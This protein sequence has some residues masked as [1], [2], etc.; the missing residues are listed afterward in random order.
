[1]MSL[2]PRGIQPRG[3]PHAGVNSLSPLEDKGIG[4]GAQTTL[5]GLK[6]P[7]LHDAQH[8]ALHLRVAQRRGLHVGLHDRTRQTHRPRQDHLTRQSRVKLQLALVAVLDGA[9]AAT[10]DRANVTLGAEGADRRAACRD[11]R[12]DLGLACSI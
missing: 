7:T 4:D 5:G 11:A 1:M 6:A 2:G 3:S 12:L 9:G 8:A 10:H